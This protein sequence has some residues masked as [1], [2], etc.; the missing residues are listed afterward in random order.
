MWSK[1]KASVIASSLMQELW[2]S[3]GVMQ[4]QQLRQPVVAKPTLIRSTGRRCHLF[5]LWAP[6]SLLGTSLRKMSHSSSWVSNVAGEFLWI[7][8]LSFW[9]TDASSGRR[10]TVMMYAW[11]HQWGWPRHKMIQSS[12]WESDVAP[13]TTRVD[14]HHH[15]VWSSHQLFPGI[16]SYHRFAQKVAIVCLGYLIVDPDE[17]AWNHD[18]SHSIWYNKYKTIL[19]IKQSI[20]LK[21]LADMKVNCD[22]ML[23]YHTLVP[24]HTP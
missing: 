14:V 24:Y 2:G 7:T 21:C 17:L 23:P 1:R 13:I 5:Y 19:E 3:I 22:S 4:L 8:L 10:Q 9:S 20:V 6:G 16:S 11:R 12:S 18:W 15:Y